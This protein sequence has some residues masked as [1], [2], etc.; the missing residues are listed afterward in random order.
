MS[1]TASTS[2]LRPGCGSPS[3]LPGWWPSAPP[4]RE[5]QA[6]RAQA[7]TINQVRE[8]RARLDAERAYLVRTER[9]SWWTAASVAEIAQA[10]ETAQTWREAEPDAA[11]AADR[12]R[13]EVRDRYG[14]DV[15]DPQAD[16]EFL[17]RALS[18]RQSAE[19]DRRRTQ[20]AGER[21]E[22][23]V[24]LAADE[25]S[26][27]REQDVDAAR[28]ELTA[29]L[30]DVDDQEAVQARPLADLHQGRPASE[31]VAT[32][33]RSAPKTR[34]SRGTAVRARQSQRGISR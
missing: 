9:D 6:R 13:R 19:V 5:E 8:L 24:L 15:G 27:S 33:P 10:W 11:R 26:A 12:I 34:S 14:V 3:P 16:R 22:A 28:T 31:A 17:A 23:A 7:A 18:Q 4:A 1:R 30:A 29:A 20:E 21:A 32:A 25:P 2:Q